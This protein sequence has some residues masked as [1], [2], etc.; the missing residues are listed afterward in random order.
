MSAT[1]NPLAMPD[2]RPALVRSAAFRL[3]HD[4]GKYVRFSAPDR[5][6]MD[7]EALRA[8]LALD[9]LATRRTDEETLSAVDLY[10]RWEREDGDLLAGEAFAPDLSALRDAVETMRRL[11]P[12]LAALAGPDLLRLDAAARVVVEKTAALHRRAAGEAG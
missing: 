10:D 12:R 2:P 6:E 4:L 9:L 11:L 8:R 3:K 7:P 5:E 1:D